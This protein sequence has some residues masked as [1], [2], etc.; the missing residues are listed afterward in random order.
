MIQEVISGC[1]QSW[2]WSA[3]RL[4]RSLGAR[5]QALVDGQSY[6]Q[7]LPKKILYTL[8]QFS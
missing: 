4:R 6:I 1:Y 2:N 3:R 5:V 7:Q 8:L